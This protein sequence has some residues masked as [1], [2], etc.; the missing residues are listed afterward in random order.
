MKITITYPPLMNEF[1]QKAMVS[2][3]RNVQYFKKPTY[4]LP[5]VHAQAASILKENNFD[6]IWDDANSQLKDYAK[7]LIDLKDYSPNLIVLESTT[8]V[9][10]AMWEA[11]KD[12]RKIL[13]ES[14]IVMTGY[15]SM[16][17]PHETL[18]NSEVD[19]VIKSNHVD[20]ILLKLCKKLEKD[21]DLGNLELDGITKKV[22]GDIRDYG[23]FQLVEKINDSAIV[24][25]DLIQWKNYAYENGN[26]LRTPGTYATSVIR[27][28][29]FGKCTFC[30]YNGPDLTFSAMTIKKSVD[31][32]EK[33]INEHGVK[34]IF[35]DSGVWYRGKE[36]ISFAK[37]IIKRGLH[38]RG[39]Y[40]GINT[41][42]EYLDE[43]TIEWLAKANF[44]FILIGLESGSNYSLDML[45][46]GYTAEGIKQNLMHMSKHGLHPHLTIMVGYYWETKEMLNDTIR[47][48]KELMFKGYART[49]QVTLC[50]PLDFTPYHQEVIKSGKILTK[51]YN[52]HDMSK[53]IVETPESHDVYYEAVKEIYSIAFHPKFIIRQIIFLFRFKI[54][55]WEFLF[56]Y[57]IRAIRRVRQHIF[58][59]TKNSTK[60]NKSSIKE[61]KLI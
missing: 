26:F 13:P 21:K 38:K 28:C 49:L 48:V 34:E 18:L 14:I 15:H 51:N 36:A 7:W 55:D 47:L 45:N 31:E 16:R 6:V 27:D 10:K 58:N 56:T 35:D 24:D 40:F 46:K 60:K 19:I 41:R 57:G 37:E 12:I 8:P 25:R 50:T 52:D 43:T 3:N 30:R 33:L 1:G 17:S 11:S 53:I 23:K 22:N 39:C 4:L 5:V 2:Q 44:R 20:F 29:Y 59:L 42:F 32:Y 54:R 9:M 61:T